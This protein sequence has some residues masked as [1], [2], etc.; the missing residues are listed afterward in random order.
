MCYLIVSI[1]D[2]C[3]LTYFVIDMFTLNPNNIS[4]FGETRGHIMDS[5]GTI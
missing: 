1:A 4:A 3:T 2:L 5:C